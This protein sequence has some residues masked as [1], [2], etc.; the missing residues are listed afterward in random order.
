MLYNKNNDR[1][2]KKWKEN[3][4]KN[5]KINMSRTREKK[6]NKALKVFL[7]ILL[8]II[9]LILG[10]GFTGY[11]YIKNKLGKVQYEEITKDKT[12]LGI[13]EETQ[14]KESQMNNF[15]NIAL[16]GVDSQTDDYSTAYRTDCIIIASINEKTGDVQLF[17]I[18]R[19]TYVQMEEKGKTKF[20]KINHA[21]YGGVQNTLKTINTNLDLN[22][23]EYALADFG[24]VKDLVDAV[25]G[26]E[27]NITQDEL[28]YINN[29]IG[30]VNEVTNSSAKRITKTGNQKLNGVQA[31][32][33]CRIRYT[34]GWDYK[35]TERMRTV[36]QKV[37]AK[38]KSMSVSEINNLLDEM[39][40]KVKTNIKANEIMSLIPKAM[41]FNIKESFGWPYS[42]TGVH[43]NGDFYGP[44][45]TLESNVVKL[46]KEVFGQN[47]YVVNST[48]KA[49]SDEIEEKT[50]VHETD[51]INI[52]N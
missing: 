9:I 22:I 34:E 4:V 25:G 15:R 7:I 2:R 26:V 45:A 42:T 21:Y 38:A 8:I 52:G 31:V 46:H 36:L 1:I 5:I 47:D 35:R 48:V 24:A 12:E 43:I 37:V 41:N 14:K 49:I 28:K 13:S 51:K 3:G 19:D 16:L 6:K 39:L 23:T 20:D 11:M 32:A 33:Y 18:Y 29:Y 50:G 44:A 17:S 10:S 27:I 40:P 30:N